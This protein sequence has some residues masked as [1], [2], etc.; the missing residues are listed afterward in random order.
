MLPHSVTTTHFSAVRLDFDK[1][2]VHTLQQPAWTSVHVHVPLTFSCTTAKFNDHRKTKR[3]LQ[4]KWT[5]AT[6]CLRAPAPE[7]QR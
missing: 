6:I 5:M 7:S 4:D 1:Y 2:T 3:W